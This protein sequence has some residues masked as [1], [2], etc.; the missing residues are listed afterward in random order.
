MLNASNEMN[1]QRLQKFEVLPATKGSLIY[2]KDD[3]QAW[4]DKIDE[5]LSRKKRKKTSYDN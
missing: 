4:T 1:E 2:V 5:F 3:A